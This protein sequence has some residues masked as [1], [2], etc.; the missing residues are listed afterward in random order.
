MVTKLNSAVGALSALLML[1]TASPAFAVA[2][3]E[4]EA[5]LAAQVEINKLLKSRVRE[6]EAEVSALRASSISGKSDQVAYELPPQD[7][8][9][10]DEGDGAL[11]EALIRR[12]SAVLPPWQKQIIPSLA[13]SHSG[14][15]TFSADTVAAGIA[16]RIGLPKGWM[17]GVSVPYVAHTKNALGDNNGFGSVSATVWKEI[18]AQGQHRPSLVGGLTYSAP[19]G[20]DVFETPVSTGS[21]FHSLTGRLGVTK[22]VDPV[23]FFGDAFYT[24][25]FEKNFDGIETRLG[26]V[27]GFTAGASLAATPRISLQASVGVAFAGENEQNGMSLSGTD[28]TIG[29]VNIGAGFVVA[30]G[31]YLSIN[32]SFGVTDD[33]PDFTLGASMPMRF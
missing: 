10:L 4:L 8:D 27:F 6:L 33:A 30:K 11:E 19:T 25:A 3:S 14:S 9:D 32:G 1:I 15:G 12:G 26:D 16:G 24:Y 13:W 2:T 23:A 5:Q 21:A 17:V 20:E 31:K 7:A 28:R 18:F 29:T 22:K